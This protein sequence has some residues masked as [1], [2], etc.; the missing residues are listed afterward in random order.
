M[1]PDTAAW[2]HP[3]WTQKAMKIGYTFDGGIRLEAG[4]THI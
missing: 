1:P 4:A 3:G 2:P